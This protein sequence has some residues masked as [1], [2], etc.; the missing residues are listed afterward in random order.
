MLDLILTKAALNGKIG[1]MT[2]RIPHNQL[3]PESEE[4]EDIDIIVTLETNWEQSKDGESEITSEF[5]E[6]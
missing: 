5:T 3:V 6:G 4:F 1:K 2:L